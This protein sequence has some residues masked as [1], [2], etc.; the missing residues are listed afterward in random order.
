MGKAAAE[1]PKINGLLRLGPRAGCGAPCFC[2]PVAPNARSR[3][4][5]GESGKSGPEP[6]PEGDPNADMGPELL[7]GKEAWGEA[8]RAEADRGQPTPRKKAVLGLGDIC[9][10]LERTWLKMVTVCTVGTV[11]RGCAG[12]RKLGVGVKLALKAQAAP[13]RKEWLVEGVE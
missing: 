6:A 8:T 13:R 7:D 5:P 12:K 1:F 9:T 10:A 3:V 4:A 11:V 2:P